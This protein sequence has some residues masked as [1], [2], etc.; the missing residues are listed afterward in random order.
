MRTLGANCDASQRRDAG[1]ATGAVVP[2]AEAGCGF[3]AAECDGWV[4]TA[5]PELRAVASGTIA[6]S[7]PVPVFAQWRTRGFRGLAVAARRA[8]KVSTSLSP[9][10]IEVRNVR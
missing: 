7:A 4:R 5:N 6:A 8:E 3:Q 2:E 1:A 9:T 10:E